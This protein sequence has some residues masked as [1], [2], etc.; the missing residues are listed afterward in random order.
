MT[1]PP[2]DDLDNLAAATEGAVNRDMDAIYSTSRSE[3]P[4]SALVLKDLSSR[5]NCWKSATG[6]ASAEWRTAAGLLDDLA[7]AVRKRGV[8]EARN[9]SY[10]LQLAA[11]H[12]AN[13][14]VPNEPLP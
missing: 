2:P 1:S 10:T 8:P 5:P 11:T 13:L 4:K 9:A 7:R 3:R 14:R 6:P 12:V